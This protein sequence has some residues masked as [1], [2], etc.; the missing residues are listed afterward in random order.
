[1]LQQLANECATVQVLASM[2]TARCKCFGKCMKC[3]LYNLCLGRPGFKI[4][5]YFC[6]VGYQTRVCYT[7][8]IRLFY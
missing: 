4:Y 8:G 5:Y 2:H 1:M 3:M 6:E 7:A